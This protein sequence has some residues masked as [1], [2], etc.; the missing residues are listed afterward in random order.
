MNNVK[1]MNKYFLKQTGLNKEKLNNESNLCKWMYC[2]RASTL[3][4]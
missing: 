2:F 4:L 3:L 1:K